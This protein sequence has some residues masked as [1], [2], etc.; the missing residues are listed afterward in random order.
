M[1]GR[2]ADLPPAYRRSE[3]EGPPRIR[4]GRWRVY[5]DKCLVRRPP[6]STPAAWRLS[7]KRSP[8]TPE[9][10]RHADHDQRREPDGATRS[11]RASLP[12]RDSPPGRQTKPTPTANVPTSVARGKRKRAGQQFRLL[13]APSQCRHAPLVSPTRLPHR[14]PAWAVAATPATSTPC[15]RRQ[16]VD[17]P[18]RLAACRSSGRMHPCQR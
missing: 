11:P 4:N 16:T 6:I 9:R 13:H 18:G 10:D 12:R 2:P 15:E 5:P 1:P 3:D 8:I 7:T 17:W 14:R